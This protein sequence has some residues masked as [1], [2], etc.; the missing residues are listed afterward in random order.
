MS[1]RSSYEQ[2]TPNWVDLQTTD[3][4]G[5]KS[6]YG[7]LFGWEFDDQPLPE[8]AGAY[9]MALKG[10]AGHVAAIAG[11]SPDMVAQNLPPMWN[12]YIAVDDVDAVTGKVD[13]AGGKVLMPPFDVMDAGRMSFVTDPS[14]A[15]VGLWQAGDHIGATVVNEHGAVVWNEL[16]TD[17]AD[18]AVRFLHDVVGVGTQDAEMGGNSYT[19][20][21]VD[22]RPVGGTTPPPMPGLPNHWHVYFQVD[23]V[24][25]AAATATAHGGTVVNG[26]FDTPIGPMAVLRDPQGALFSVMSPSAEAAE[27]QP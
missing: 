12:T 19:M 24:P 10:S 4:E 25:A 1:E 13:A 2:G 22:D 27:A 17:D 8:G 21:T 26:P 6:F 16:I 5:A 23:D 11:Q 3:Q 18:S 15:A 14:G 7:S 20:F 9:S